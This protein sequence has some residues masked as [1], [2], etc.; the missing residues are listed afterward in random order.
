[1]LL[2]TISEVFGTLHTLN[3]NYLFPIYNDAKE[4]NLGDALYYYAHS[5]SSV[6]SKLCKKKVL[7][8]IQCSA[9]FWVE[10]G[11]PA[12]EALHSSMDHLSLNWVFKPLKLR[13]QTKRWFPKCQDF[14]F[15]E[16]SED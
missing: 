8:E 16:T 4:M 5:K 6:E 3:P 2:S 13:T 12:E 10:N 9:V 7:Q 14:I 15:T 1:M 11:L